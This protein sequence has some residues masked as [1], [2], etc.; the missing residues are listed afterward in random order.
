MQTKYNMT[1]QTK[2]DRDAE[3]GIYT[4]LKTANFYFP[5]ADIGKK[6]KVENTYNLRI[7]DKETIKKYDDFE[8]MGKKFKNIGCMAFLKEYAD[9]FW[10]AI[11]EHELDKEY[12]GCWLVPIRLS[13]F[14]EELEVDLDVLRPAS[15]NKKKR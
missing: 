8:K 3:K 9:I 4:I 1:K 10:F 5:L 11:K 12:R 15:S 7:T 2:E 13:R 6:F 14:G